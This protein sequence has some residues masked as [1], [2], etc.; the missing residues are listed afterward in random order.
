MK[1]RKV[2][3]DKNLICLGF[4]LENLGAGNFSTISKGKCQ[5]RYVYDG[6]KA[7]GS[8]IRRIKSFFFLRPN[9]FFIYA[10]NYNLVLIHN[11]QLSINSVSLEDLAWMT[12]IEK[13]SRS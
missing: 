2:P 4:G 7:M 8:T 11:E 12:H 1:I 5:Y 13:H 3:L 6:E 9:L 10:S